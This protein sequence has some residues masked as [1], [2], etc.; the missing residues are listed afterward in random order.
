MYL[1]KGYINK[2]GLYRC[3]RPICHGADEAV[4]KEQ[5]VSE[6]AKRGVLRVSVW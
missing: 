5:H 1:I 2:Q 3:Y 6:V 4:D